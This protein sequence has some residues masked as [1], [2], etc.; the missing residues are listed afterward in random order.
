MEAGIPKKLSYQSIAITS[1]MI[2]T[3]PKMRQTRQSNDLYSLSNKPL[4]GVKRCKI[5]LG[6]VL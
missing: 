2:K 1:W 5:R 3:L 4:N 6:C